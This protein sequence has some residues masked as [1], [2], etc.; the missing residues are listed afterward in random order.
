[1]D[2]EAKLL[3]IEKRVDEGEKGRA[4]ENATT[5]RELADHKNAINALGGDLVSLRATVGKFTVP[6]AAAAG[7]TSTTKKDAWGKPLDA[8]GKVVALPPAPP[9]AP[10]PAPGQAPGCSCVEHEPAHGP[11]GCTVKKCSCSVTG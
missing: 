4:A 2:I 6:P 9:A 3:E 11:N 10:A 7:A 1:M 5:V 8:A